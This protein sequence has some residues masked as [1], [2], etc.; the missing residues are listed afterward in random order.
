MPPCVVMSCDMPAKKS[1]FIRSQPATMTAAEV[2]KLAR[3]AGIKVDEHYVSK[4]RSAAKVAGKSSKGAMAKKAASKS[5]AKTAPAKKASVS[6]ADTFSKSDFVRARPHLSPKEIV[7]DA[8]DYGMKLTA[9]HVYNVRSYD[10]AKGTKKSAGKKAS[11][12]MKVGPAPVAPTV[13][14]TNGSSSSRVEDLLKA[15]ATELGLGHAIEILQG[16]RARVRAVIGG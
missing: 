6:K 13:A 15:V 14:K 2:V 1:A 3:G 5:P 12:I 16:E 4:I 8:R 7:E 9:N 11:V 10:A